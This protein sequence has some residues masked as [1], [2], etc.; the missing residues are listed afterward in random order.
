MPEDKSV[1]CDNCNQKFT[2]DVEYV[3]P[4][5]YIYW[6]ECIPGMLYQVVVKRVR[7]F[8]YAKEERT[9]KENVNYM[10]MKFHNYGVGKRLTRQ[11]HNL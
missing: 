2:P 9:A 8:Y 10:L 5:K 3:F 11:T 6:H 1:I 4:N 7:K